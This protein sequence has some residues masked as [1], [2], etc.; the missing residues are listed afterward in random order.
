MSIRAYSAAVSR[1]IAAPRC[2]AARARSA[3]SACRALPRASSRQRASPGGPAPPPACCW[4][5]T[6]R[7]AH[8]VTASACRPVAAHSIAQYHR[9]LTAM[10]N[11]SPARMA[12]WSPSRRCA[13]ASRIRPARISRSA[14]SISKDGRLSSSPESRLPASAAA[15]V[16]AALARSP[17]SISAMISRWLSPRASQPGRPARD[18]CRRAS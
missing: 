10:S 14:V 3:P 2:S 13:A 16:L 1:L 11:Q 6:S 9:P 7:A 8:I 5:W 18:C 15:Q 12:A 17:A 4:V